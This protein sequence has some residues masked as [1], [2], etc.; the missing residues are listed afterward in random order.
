MRFSEGCFLLILQPFFAYNFETVSFFDV[1]S[2]SLERA[3]ENG[4]ESS[5]I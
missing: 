2:I 4:L 5:W 1:F 3:L